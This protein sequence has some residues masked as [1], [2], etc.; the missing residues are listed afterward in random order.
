MFCLV[1]F[2]TAK[3]KLEIREESEV[4]VFTENDGIE[5]NEETLLSFCPN[6][7]CIV[8]EGEWFP[9]SANGTRLVEATTQ[10]SIQNTHLKYVDVRLQCA[11]GEWIKTILVK[12]CC[13]G[14]PGLIHLWMQAP[15]KNRLKP[16]GVPGVD[17]R[18]SR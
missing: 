13:P 17:P 10:R 6:T 16:G 7:I 15:S 5:V 3:R 4:S 12:K 1:W 8:G 14:P 9:A 18:A 11:P 2:D